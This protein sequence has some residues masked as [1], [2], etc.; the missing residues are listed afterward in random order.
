MQHIERGDLGE[1]TCVYSAAT[2]TGATMHVVA[3]K[4]PLSTLKGTPT[5]SSHSTTALYET[6]LFSQSGGTWMCSLVEYR[7]E[8]IFSGL[9][10]LFSAVSRC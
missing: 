4:Y 7:N 2:M 9:F 10:S 1:T 8:I 5:C 3:V 6:D